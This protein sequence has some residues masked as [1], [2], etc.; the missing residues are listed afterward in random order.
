MVLIQTVPSVIYSLDLDVFRLTLKAIEDTSDGMAFERTHKHNTSVTVGG[1]LCGVF[2]GGGKM[3]GSIATNCH[4]IVGVKAVL[5]NGDIIETGT[6]TNKHSPMFYRG[7]FG[8][9]RLSQHPV[10]T[11]AQ[12][13][14]RSSATKLGRPRKPVQQCTI[15]W[16]V[17][18]A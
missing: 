5:P 1:A 18:S 9:D 2:G 15:C 13:T 7:A 3:F 6:R 8:P 10:A 14:D 11:L 16:I 17:G 12:Y 4:E